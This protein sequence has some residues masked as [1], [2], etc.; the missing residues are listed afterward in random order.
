MCL[1]M[2]SVSSLTHSNLIVSESSEWTYE[3]Y[4][5]SQ[6]SICIYK[7]PF[8]EVKIEC[9]VLLIVRVEGMNIFLKI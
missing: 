9:H 6:S 5:C 3:L 8:I 2:N 7:I 4:W 1:V